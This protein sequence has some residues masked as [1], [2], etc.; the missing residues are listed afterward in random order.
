MKYFKEVQD[1]IFEQNLAIFTGKHLCW[2]VFFKKLQDFKIIDVVR[3]FLLL[4]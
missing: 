4:T 1:I 3:V 2:K